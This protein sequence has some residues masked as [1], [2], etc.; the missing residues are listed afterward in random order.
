MFT[1]QVTA[2]KLQKKSVGKFYSHDTLIPFL[3]YM[4]IRQLAAARKVLQRTRKID[5]IAE[6]LSKKDRASY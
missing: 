5:Q 1:A 6:T 3:S 2:R 4:L